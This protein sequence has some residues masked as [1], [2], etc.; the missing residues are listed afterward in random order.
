MYYPRQKVIEIEQEAARKGAI[1][2]QVLREQLSKSKAQAATAKAES[3]RFEQELREEREVGLLPCCGRC[4]A[5]SLGRE[6]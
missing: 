5:L 3:A 1:D 2:L 6:H 4:L